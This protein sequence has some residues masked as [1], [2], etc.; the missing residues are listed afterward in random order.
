MTKRRHPMRLKG[1]DYASS[2]AYFVTICVRDRL[3]LFGR[4]REARMQ[5]NPA[6]Q[7]LE[8]WWAELGRKFPSVAPDWFAVMPNHVHG[9]LL[10]NA[11]VGADLCVGP[12]QA[13]HAGRPQDQGGH[14]GPPLPRVMQWFKTMTTNAY[15]QGVKTDGWTAFPGRLWQRGYYEHIIHDSASMERVRQYIADNPGQWQMDAENPMAN[16]DAVVV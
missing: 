13:E 6:G 8:G 5:C 14:A 12:A 16:I 4:I 15:L 2:G 3:P 9:I 11:S 10:M 1:F 7:M